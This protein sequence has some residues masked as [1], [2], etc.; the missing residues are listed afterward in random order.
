MGATWT[1]RSSSHL[2]PFSRRWGSPS[3]SAM[4]HPI[5]SLKS[6]WRMLKIRSNV[7]LSCQRIGSSTNLPVKVAG[8]YG[9]DQ[10]HAPPTG[11]GYS[12][13][14]SIVL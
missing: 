10:A 9:R 14:F 6:A 1:P 13:L 2:M 12:T 11:P 3:S 4:I 8:L 5:P 7:W